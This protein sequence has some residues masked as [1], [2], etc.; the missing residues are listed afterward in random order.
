MIKI[1]KVYD[2]KSVLKD[3]IRKTDVIYAT[4]LVSDNKIYLKTENLQL[5]GSFK[6]RGS[7]YKISKLTEEE[8]KKGIVAS[9][10]GNHAQGVALA[11]QE[12]NIPCIICMPD[13]APLS[14]VE[15]TKNYGA[16]VVLAEGAYD[17]A[18][19]CARQLCDEKDMTFIHPFDDEDVISGQG[20][21][22]LE[23]LEQLD[24]VDAI[25]VPVGGGGLIS[26]VAFAAKSLKP[27]IKIYG[28]Q[29]QNAASMWKSFYDNKL[30]SIPKAS[31][32][33]DG[34]AVKTPGVKTFEIVQQY[35]DEIITVSEDEIAAAILMLMEKQKLVAEGAGA[36]S[37]AA[38]IFNKIPLK[39]KNIVCIVSGG[40]I[41]INII[42]RVMTR[43]LLLSG[44]KTSFT[45]S[46]EDK[47]G[48]LMGV[49]KVI[50]D[51]GGNV[52]AIDYDNGDPEM[53]ITSCFITI[54]LETRN[55]Q[56]LNQIKKSLTE[57]GFRIVKERT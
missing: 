22:G 55:H 2:A 42:D 9:S 29:A 40:N 34:I 12:N 16:E 30:S 52:V 26:G 39:G 35:V 44:R 21:I 51:N 27:S 1:N 49:A 43:G 32:F 4:N 14:K 13:S 33:A 8:K 48:Q 25:V 5:T 17:E 19:E 50:S 7:Y 18:Y 6:I 53:D 11:A 10:A 3:V 38:A 37:V 56:H 23:I 54:T 28:V 45:I 57:N 31:T 47:P 15:A 36:V 24:D 41:D 20:T 46:L